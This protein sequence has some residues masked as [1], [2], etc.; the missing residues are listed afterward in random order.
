MKK[1]KKTF[2]YEEYQNYLQKDHFILLLHHNRLTK[3][4]N[5]LI[6]GL[7][8]AITETSLD[9]SSYDL[10]TYLTLRLGGVVGNENEDTKNLKVKVI[11]NSIMRKL[12]LSTYE[13]RQFSHFAASL[14]GPTLMI[15]YSRPTLQIIK[16]IVETLMEMNK[17]KEYT[18]FVIL[19]GIF[20]NKFVRTT[21]SDLTHFLS[22]D[23]QENMIYNKMVLSL[24]MGIYLTQ[25]TNTIKQINDSQMR[26]LLHSVS[27][28]GQE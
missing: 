3:H 14:H 19:G 8:P 9:Y 25:L 28:I 18:D 11:K 6:P 1:N 16:R 17:Q 23:S 21:S 13:L 15:S 2:I 7:R 26:Q 12:L 10:T 22:L 24:D 27:S 20:D 4:G 5:Q